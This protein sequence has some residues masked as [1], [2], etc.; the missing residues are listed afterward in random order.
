MKTILISLCT[1]GLVFGQAGTC[2]GIDVGSNLYGHSSWHGFVGGSATS[3]YK[4]NISGD[5]VD[6]HSATWMAR[7]DGSAQNEKVNLGVAVSEARNGPWEGFNV[8]YVHGN[9]Q[10]RMAVRYN[11]L[12][13]KT[14]VT[15]AMTAGSNVLTVSSWTPASIQG[16][17]KPYFSSD[18]IGKVVTVAGACTGTS[19]NPPCISGVLGG[20]P[21][22][23]YVA[24]VISPTQVTLVSVAGFSPAA[25][26]T[27][28]GATTTVQ[29]RE[30]SNSM[31]PGT[32]PAPPS[33][34]IQ[35]WFSPHS[36]P[37][38]VFLETNI[39]DTDQHAFIVDVDNCIGYEMYKCYDDGSNL[40]CGAY[41]A[42]YL[43]GGDLQR[44]YNITGGATVAGM[45]E[46]PG[47]LRYDEFSSGVIPHA[48]NM[49]ALLGNS[50][51]AFTGPASYGQYGAWTSNQIPF[52]SKLRLKV[53]FDRTGH[54]ASCK[55]LFDEM[56][57][58]GLIVVDGGY[59]GQLL[60]EVNYNWP[61]DCVY[62]LYANFRINAANFEV[63][64]QPVDS[65]IY[66]ANGTAG[67]PDTLPAGSAPAIAN[68][69]A[70]P[71]TIT[72]GQSTTLHWAVSGAVDV[73]GND[74]HIRNI[75]YGVN[76][77]VDCS[78]QPCSL[79]P[80]WIDGPAHD[81]SV[82]M[83]PQTSGT[84]VY[85]LMAQNRFGRTKANVSVTVK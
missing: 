68:F 78:A 6:S 23:L 71:A 81:E 29:L 10:R 34:R 5:P 1:A 40:S 46:I 58:Y 51:P 80:G 61:Y 75:S 9:T 53:D 65:H 22:T 27:V 47:L 63:V 18:D 21:G 3:T 24:S 45:P 54:P 8:H 17:Q 48:L 32:F 42:F 11:P 39:P 76:H 84:Y 28:S 85:Q 14:A 73:D 13:G 69:T 35:S 55:P 56:Q 16:Q 79:G 25:T 66:C 52:G 60:Q 50:T 49:T 82:V 12:W 33:I 7:L 62:D 2:R 57:N 15:G 59:T 72:L 26:M 37:W 36:R 4:R 64:Q 44:P 67:C 70:S 38:G 41:A 19:Q 31:D 74:M 77:A 20:N 43:P 83:T 30:G